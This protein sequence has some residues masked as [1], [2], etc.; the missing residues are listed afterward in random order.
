MASYKVATKSSVEA[1]LMAI[2]F[3]F[4][5]QINQHIMGLRDNPRPRGH[6]SVGDD[7]FLLPLFGWAILYEV[8]D[9]AL[10]VTVLALPKVPDG[11]V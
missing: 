3:P 11:L 2:P 10:V 4:R 6:R 7:H 1:E 8:D 5:R 9:D